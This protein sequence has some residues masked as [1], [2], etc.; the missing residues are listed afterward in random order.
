MTPMFRGGGGCVT[1]EWL[2]R[3]KVENEDSVREKP[4]E[5]E[6]GGSQEI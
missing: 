2:V 1:L 3:Q 5:A 6:V 4:L